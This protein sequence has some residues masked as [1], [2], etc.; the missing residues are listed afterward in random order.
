MVRHGSSGAGDDCQVVFCQIGFSL[1]LPRDVRYTIIKAIRKK[2]NKGQFYRNKV[3]RIKRCLLKPSNWPKALLFRNSG[4]NFR[5][6]TQ[7][8]LTLGEASP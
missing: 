5:E 4:G 2:N 6:E 3:S 7:Q 8:L 1:S